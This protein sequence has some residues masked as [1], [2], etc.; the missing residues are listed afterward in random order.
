MAAVMSWCI[1]P[2]EN[3]N[4]VTEDGINI[5]IFANK[6]GGEG[7]GVLDVAPR[8]RYIVRVSGIS[9][10]NF[11]SASA[12]IL[13]SSALLISPYVV[14]NG[15]VTDVVLVSM[16]Q[17]MVRI[18]HGPLVNSESMEDT[19]KQTWTTQHYKNYRSPMMRPRNP[20]DR[21]S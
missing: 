18:S 19:R 15:I 21:D 2:D 10:E 6:G 16:N 4:V 14:E 11:H 13:F 5:T 1:L 20:P 8:F 12:K 3:I 17:R 9:L 7:I